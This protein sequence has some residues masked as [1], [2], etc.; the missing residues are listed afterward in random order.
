MYPSRFNIIIPDYPEP[1]KYLCFNTLTQSMVVLDKDI[2][3]ILKRKKIPSDNIMNIKRN[4]IKKLILKL[5]PQIRFILNISKSFEEITSK[6]YPLALKIMEPR[7]GISDYVLFNYIDFENTKAFASSQC[8]YL[9]DE[10]EKLKNKI[11]N[12]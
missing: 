5:Y 12:Y 3:E 10:D 8:I 11:I 6:L 4:K 7:E 2:V 9:V 1:K